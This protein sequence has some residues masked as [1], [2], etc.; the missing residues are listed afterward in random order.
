MSAT[1]SG[2][3]GGGRQSRGVVY[4]NAGEL[5]QQGGARRRKHGRLGARWI[6]KVNRPVAHIG[7]RG[8]RGELGLQPKSCALYTPSSWPSSP[9]GPN[10][11]S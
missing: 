1:K 5:C 11:L 3:R 4:S 7:E 8:W 10:G 9:N 6:G 2:G